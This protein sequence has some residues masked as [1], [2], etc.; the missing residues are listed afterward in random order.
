MKLARVKRTTQKGE[1]VEPTTAPRVFEMRDGSSRTVDPG[2]QAMTGDAIA[3]GALVS[4]VLGTVNDLIREHVHKIEAT[5][6]KFRQWKA[7]VMQAALAGDPKLA[8]WKAKL[9]YQS[10]PYYVA[11]YEALA[12][13][14]ADLR[15]LEEVRDTMYD[16]A[17]TAR[18]FI[19][20]GK[21]NFVAELN[22][23][24][25]QPTGRVRPATPS[26]EE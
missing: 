10:D 9:V 19:N 18:C 13:L 24:H 15:W 2:W 1:T 22:G 25:P 16:K 11:V 12:G 21:A 5:Q 23:G 6:A 3:D 17:A 7:G 4:S 14:T 26:A 20:N 8:E